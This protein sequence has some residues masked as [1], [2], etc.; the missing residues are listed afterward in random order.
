MSLLL[1]AFSFFFF[2]FFN[3]KCTMQVHRSQTKPDHQHVLVQTL[4]MARATLHASVCLML[5]CLFF[6]SAS[7]YVLLSKQDLFRFPVAF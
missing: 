2:F 7:N 4:G 6:N 5:V 3:W 1:L